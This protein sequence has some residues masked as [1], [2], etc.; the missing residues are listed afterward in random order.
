[1]AINQQSGWTQLFGRLRI[2]SLSTQDISRC[3]SV[4]SSLIGGGA[5]ALLAIATS[6]KAQQV[7]PL[8][9]PPN[10]S[11]PDLTTVPSFN[12]SAIG[13]GGETVFLAPINRQG[14]IEGRYVVYVNGDSPYLLQQVRLIEPTASVQPY[15]GR[16]IIQAGTFNNEA[17][18]QQQVAALRSQGIMA[19]IAT[20][21][22]S[23][24][25][26]Q[27]SHYLVIIPGSRD[28]LPAL[29][30][31]AVRM[32]IRQE[33]I[34]QKDAPLGPH[35]EIGPFAEHEDAKKISQ[36]LNGGGFDAR[37]YYGR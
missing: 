19:D 25:L 5:I 35:L 12:N 1:M 21:N 8:P 22:A 23:P 37:V 17:S 32:G 33:A 27:T 36:F 4:R 15:Q 18:A 11:V 7:I 16:S 31:Q 34:Q 24:S 2:Q 28:D 9:P 26:A 20:L 6:S 13:A 30:N 14:N 3:Q 29:A 10:V